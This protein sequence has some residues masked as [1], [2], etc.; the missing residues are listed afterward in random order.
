MQEKRVTT[1]KP[2][3]QGCHLSEMTG[4]ATSAS[5]SWLNDARLLALRIRLEHPGHRMASLVFSQL[6]QNRVSDNVG[7]VKHYSSVVVRALGRARHFAL[8]EE[9]PYQPRLAR[10]RFQVR[11]SVRPMHLFGRNFDHDY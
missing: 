6:L 1:D 2:P 7:G 4:G 5:T 8:V 10:N 9:L 11:N 3:S